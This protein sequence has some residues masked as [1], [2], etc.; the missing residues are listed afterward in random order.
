MRFN[1][2]NIAVAGLM[3][4]TIAIASLPVVNAAEFG[5]DGEI[6]P[7]FWGSLAEEYSL[8]SE[9]IAQSPIDI[10]SGLTTASV[11]DELKT[12]YDSTPLEVENNGHTIEVVMA[13]GSTIKT[14]SGE[15]ALL[16]FHFHF[17]SEHTVDGNH[18]ALEAHFVHM[19]SN[20]QLAVL[21]VFIDEGDENTALK[22][23]LENAPHDIGINELHDDL[24]PE[25]ILPDDKV[26]H[27]WNYSGSLTTPP[28][29]EG[30]TWYVA[31]EHIT[32][33]REQ[34]EAMATLLHHNNYR[35][36]QALNGRV[37]SDSDED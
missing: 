8:C 34:I 1:L 16:Q 32:A 26:E 9:G 21:G 10:I 22:T 27:Y 14:P 19:N 15:Y 29:S 35:P 3:S 25:D 4:S 33:S 5:Y 7:E 24:D 17:E 31:Q 23:I 20:G 11:L 30:V 28:C 37:I 18:S 36:T 2:K 6:G 13:P 12:D